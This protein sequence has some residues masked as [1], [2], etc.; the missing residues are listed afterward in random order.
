MIDTENI[1][2]VDLHLLNC[3]VDI[4]LQALQLYSFNF[5]NVWCVNTDSILEDLRNA[6]IFH[7]YE[8][9]SDIYSSNVHNYDTL[10]Q[11]RLT[12]RRKKI[13]NFTKRKKIA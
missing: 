8:Q 4:I 5:H 7:T 12:S 3:Q 10:K 1:S 11:C 13:S 6:L 2:Y 9:I